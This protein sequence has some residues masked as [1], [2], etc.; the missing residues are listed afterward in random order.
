M[1]D[2]GAEVPEWYAGQCPLVE[3]DRLILGVG[4]SD[5]LLMAVDGA[6]G[7]VIWKTPN[8]NH[9]RMTHSSVVPMEFKGRRMYVYCASGGVVAVSATDGAILWEYP[10]WRISI[11]NIPSPIV[12][13]DGRIFFTGGYDAGSLMLQVTETGG[14]LTVA[15]VF[16]LTAKLF[17]AAQQTP[18]LYHDHLFGVRADGQLV[19]LDLNGKVTWQSGSTHKFGYGPFL[20]AQELLFV[21]DDSGLLTLAE[22]SADGYK[23]LAQ[24]KVLQ[25][26][27]AWGPMALADGRLI[28]RDMNQM[29]CLEVG[30]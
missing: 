12:A 1:K 24:A 3:G 23:Q 28:L 30:R 17:G 22:I 18:L 9:W 19:C 29:I 14:K 25:G 27:D 6:T 16:R 5:A 20:I 13:G 2:F 15:P 4:G 7:K 26:P 8:P 21:M 11:A 10:D